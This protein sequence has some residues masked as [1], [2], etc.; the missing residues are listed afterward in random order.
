MRES[1]ST[2]AVGGA[3]LVAL[4]W[5]AAPAAGAGSDGANRVNDPLEPINRRVFWFNE[6]ADRWL[7]EP[8]GTVWDW[9][10]PHRVQT[11]IRNLF[12]NAR[13]PVV[14]VNDL[15]QAKPKQAAEDLA[16]FALNTTVGVA[17][18]FDPAS[19]VGL[20]ANLEDFGQTLGYWGVPP[21]PYLV[22]PLLGPSNPRDT[23]GLAV[24]SVTRVYPY[25]LDW[26]INAAITATDLINR[27]A[28]ALEMIREERKNAFDFYA[29][30]RNAHVQ[31][32]ENLVKDSERE[33]TDISDDLYYFEE[34]DEEN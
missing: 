4:L 10:V 14:F 26:W 28:L 31:L 1:S 2:R 19:R 15:L 22:W 27:R 3:L 7:F 33:P 13:F 25:F 23:V 24:D 32:R 11:S 16:R 29:F 12:E 20:E 18:L 17:G 5:I 34:D 8:A 21:G 6:Q 30:V 9:V